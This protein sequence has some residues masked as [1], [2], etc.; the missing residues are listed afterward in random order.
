[1]LI[2]KYGLNDPMPVQYFRWLSELVRGNLGWSQTAQTSVMDGIRERFPSTFELSLL[3]LM[4]VIFV[5]IWLGILSA[6]HHNRLLD[7]FL[8]FLAITGYSFPPFVVGIL[9]LM[10]FYGIVQWFPPGQLSFWAERVAYGQ[11]F[12][13]YT[14]MYTVDALLNKR[15]DIFW[16]ALRHL[17][18]PVLTLAYG[19]WAGLLRV[20]RSS[21]LE[22]LR[23]DYITTARAKGLS[24]RVVI[25]KHARRNALISVATV[26]GA[27]VI[28]LLGG[29]VIIETIFGLKGLGQWAAE[30]TVQLDVPAVL[31]VTMLG[32]ATV[33][34]GNLFVDLLYTWID[35]RIRLE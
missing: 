22:A 8:R 9:L 15:P 24:E 2:E 28:G 32:T 10:V 29:V 20:T 34:L 5:A 12:V 33:V 30:A 27:I 14:G 18:L 23:K 17:L 4:P 16:D 13:H 6:V 7:H 25:H 21:M 19:F 1:R 35:P 31:G 11:D 26:S 3:A